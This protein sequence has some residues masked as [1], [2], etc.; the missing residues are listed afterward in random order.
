M[1]TAGTRAPQRYLLAAVLAAGPG[2]TVADASGQPTRPSESPYMIKAAALL[3]DAAEQ[4]KVA[5]AA[6]T[7]A[8]S[9]EIAKKNAARMR[10]ESLRQYDL[11]WLEDGDASALF[12]SAGL[13]Y[14]LERPVAA[15]DAAER[16]LMAIDRSD[17]RHAARIQPAE[18]LVLGGRKALDRARPDPEEAA[19]CAAAF[20]E[21]RKGVIQV[22]DP[23]RGELILLRDDDTGAIWKSTCVVDLGDPAGVSGANDGMLWA[24]IGLVV[25]AVTLGAVG[26]TL[27][28]RSPDH[29]A[30]E[31]LDRYTDDASL[32]HGL[33]IG[34]LAAGAV[35]A[36]LIIGGLTWEPSGPQVKGAAL[37]RATTI[38]IG[39]VF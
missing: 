7:P 2:L 21:V 12:F 17:P 4:D 25:I 26:V 10:R 18:Q 37:P 28:A 27:A 11:A 39:G 31:E 38:G 6:V 30:R 35:G 1:Q 22:P 13:L 33:G 23:I 29:V 16:F 24:G 8:S 36:G 19:R 9:K 5:E 15:A 32:G 14:I 34:A 20:A 3:R